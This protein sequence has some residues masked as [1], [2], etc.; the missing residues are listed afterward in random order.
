MRKDDENV[1]KLELFS[2][3]AGESL[4]DVLESRQ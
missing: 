4:A 1:K 2:G 3:S